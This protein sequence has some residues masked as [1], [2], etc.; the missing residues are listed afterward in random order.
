M[1]LDLGR[2]LDQAQS[3]HPAARVGPATFGSGR[4]DA[5]SAPP[6]RTA[7]SRPSRAGNP[8]PRG[9]GP[10]ARHSAS[11]R[12]GGRALVPFHAADVHTVISRAC[13]SSRR[14]TSNVRSPSAGT[15][16]VNGRE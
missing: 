8:A 4:D 11:R 16:S 10:A 15:I 2:A 9:H 6:V 12:P 13:S 1:V 14:G 3:L 5:R 7:C